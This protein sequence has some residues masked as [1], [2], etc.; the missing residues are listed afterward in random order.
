MKEVILSEKPLIRAYNSDCMLAME[1]MRE[2]EYELAIVDPE[3]GIGIGN[4]PRLVKDKGLVAKDWDNKTID[5]S[6]FC[7]VKNISS[8]QIIWGGNYYSLGPSKHCIIWD[9]VQP[10]TFSFGMFDFAWTSF[11]KPNKIFK[12]SVLHEK[13]KIHPTQ[14]PVSLYRFL[15]QNYATPGDRILDT[16]GGSMSIAIACHMEGYDLDI[17]EKDEEYFEAAVKRFKAYSSQL[18]M[19]V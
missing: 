9:K 15:I 12:Q 11:S 5:D 17:W 18:N 19:F 13:N 8:N 16:H 6:Y 10:I 1:G 2:N 3:F 14:K 4:S 7:R